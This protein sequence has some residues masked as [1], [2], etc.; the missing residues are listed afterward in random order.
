MLAD[1]DRAMRADAHRSGEDR[2]LTGCRCERHLQ[3]LLWTRREPC[4]WSFEE[5]LAEYNSAAEVG[6]A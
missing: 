3:T 4:G 6:A 2:E 5:V 1:V